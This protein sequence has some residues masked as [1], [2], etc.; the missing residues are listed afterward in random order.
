MAVH[1]E[2]S[3]TCLSC[4]E[5][6]VGPERAGQR[7]GACSATRSAAGTYAR[8]MALTHQT[9]PGSIYLLTPVGEWPIHIGFEVDG[10]CGVRQPA[11]HLPALY[12]TCGGE[13]ALEPIPTLHAGSR[14]PCAWQAGA[15]GHVRLCSLPAD[16]P[17]A[18]FQKGWLQCS[19][20]K[21]L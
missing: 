20:R 4:L 15:L 10:G 17:W 2:H 3:G 21:T 14:L 16:W 1:T 12:L 13:D 18:K 9:R 5:G 7:R 6:T 19:M 8:R 11:V